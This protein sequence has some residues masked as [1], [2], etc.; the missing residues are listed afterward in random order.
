MATRRRIEITVETEQV[1]VTSQEMK[2]TAWCDECQ[3]QVLM[4]GVEQAAQLTGLRWRELLR[5]A[6]VGAFHCYEPADGSWQ[7]CL[8]S[9]SQWIQR[10]DQ[11]TLLLSARDLNEEKASKAD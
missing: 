6:D 2:L 10:A 5:Q 4:V 11:T 3:R 7:I 9:V 8:V 1:A